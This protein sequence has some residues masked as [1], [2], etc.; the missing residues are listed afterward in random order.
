MTDA[1]HVGQPPIMGVAMFGHSPL[2]LL[3]LIRG[4]ISAD[5]STQ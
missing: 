3:F 1:S 4:V 5:H 2:V